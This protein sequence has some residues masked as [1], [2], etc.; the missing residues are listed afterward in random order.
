M[1]SALQKSPIPK[2]HAYLARMLKEPVFDPHWHFHSEHQLFL[3]LKGS[4]T[5]FIGDSVKSYI[6]GD[7]TFIGP[8]LPH[9]WRSEN[10]EEQEMNIAWSEG[11]VIYFHKDFLGKNLLQSNE[12][13]RLRNVFHKSLRGIEFTHKTAVTLKTMMIDLVA[14]TGFDGVLQL[15]KILNFIST[16]NEFNLLASAGYTNTLREADTERM[17]KVYAFVM[18]NFKQ[19]IFLTDLAKLTNMTPT[20]FSRYFKQHANK[21]FS[22]FVSEI[23][24]GHACKLLIEK[25][26]NVSQACYQSGYQTLSNF[27]KQFKHI[28]KLTPLAYKK[29]YEIY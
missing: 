15:L 27:N 20:S 2:H 5:R 16:T 13:I 1:K 29:K 21:P 17:F 18:K 26:M 8:D 22:D 12:A 28:T 11:I 14:M 24:I 4:G 6:A 3:V 10:E 25:K 23:R 7:I 19:K 9:L